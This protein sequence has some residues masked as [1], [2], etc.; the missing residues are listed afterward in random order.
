MVSPVLCSIFS[1]RP[2]LQIVAGDDILIQVLQNAQAGLGHKGMSRCHRNMIRRRIMS[3]DSARRA[4]V[5]NS[6]NEM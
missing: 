4:D 3:F 6:I 1:E 2:F 5:K